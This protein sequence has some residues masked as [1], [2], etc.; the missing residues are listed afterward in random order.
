MGLPKRPEDVAALY[1]TCVSIYDESE[2]TPLL[3]IA[4]PNRSFRSCGHT[5]A[6][7]IPSVRRWCLVESIL[8]LGLV[9]RAIDRSLKVL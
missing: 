3:W 1:C 6:N 9:T 7:R 5:D 8:Y 4:Q 2:G